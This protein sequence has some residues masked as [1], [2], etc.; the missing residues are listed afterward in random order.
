MNM[1]VESKMRQSTKEQMV[2]LIEQ[3][4]QTFPDVT[5]NGLVHRHQIMSLIQQQ[6]KVPAAFWQSCQNPDDSPNQRVY[7]LNKFANEL[8][9]VTFALEAVPFVKTDIAKA[10]KQDAE[11]DFS[12]ELTPEIDEN[13]IPFGSYPTIDTLISSGIFCPANITG[14]SG[15]GKSKTVEQVCAK[16]KRE[17]IRVNITKWS[18]EDNLIGTK[19]L[20]DGNVEIVEGPVLIA[21]RRGAILLLDEFDAGNAN[22]MMCLQSILEGGQYYFKLK[23]EI[24]K[25]AP[26]FNIITT[27]NTKGKGSDSGRYIGTQVLNEAFLDR[28]GITIEQPYPSIEIEQKILVNHLRST[29]V[30]QAIIDKLVSSDKIKNLCVWADTIR[31]SFDKGSIDEQITTRRLIHIVKNYA[32]FGNMNT[33]VKLCCAR[34]DEHTKRAFIELFEAIEGG[35]DVSQGI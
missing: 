29:G 4:K 17:M 7:D 23:N 22:N 33:V 30:R 2:V 15:N 14:E 25:P 5:L 1:Q 26:G 24:I 28:I 9:G 18:D 21:M 27:S 12:T 13:Y 31:I 16:N 3:L 8:Q 11:A 10:I 34:F 35:K 19:T 32:I 6:V 20:I